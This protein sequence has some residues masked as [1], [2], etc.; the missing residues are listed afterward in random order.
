MVAGSLS[1]S[2]DVEV[3]V[4]D[5]A[6]SGSRVDCLDVGSLLEGSLLLC[7]GSVCWE[8]PAEDELDPC[9]DD[10]VDDGSDVLESGSDEV[11]VDR[12]GSDVRTVVVVVL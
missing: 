4:V 8:E 10:D 5:V 3:G 6:G 2:C 1:G 9:V 12:V 11:L 7:C